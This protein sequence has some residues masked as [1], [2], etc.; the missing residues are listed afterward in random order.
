MRQPFRPSTL[1]WGLLVALGGWGLD[2]RLRAPGHRALPWISAAFLGLLAL[3]VL[4]LIRNWRQGRIP[5]TRVLL[6]IL[7]LVE[8]LGLILTRASGLALE[9]RLGTVL[10]LEVLLLV[11]AVGAWRQAR[12]LPGEW[13]EDR[14]AA[15]FE[16]FVP[17][18]AA[19]LMALELVMLGS[20][21]RYLGGGFRD[22]APEGFSHHRESGL[23]A[24]LP[25]LPLLIPGDFLL[26]KVLFSGLAPWLRWV[27]HGSTVYAVLWLFGF[28]AALKARPHQ[29]HEGQVRL[30]QGLVKSVAFPAP[31]V[32]SAAPLPEFDDDWARHAHMKGVQR[33]VARG[34]PVLELKLSEPVRVLGLLGPGCPTDRLAVSVDDPAAFLTALGQPCA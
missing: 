18:K 5:G 33:L 8:G 24:F 9:L 20:A 12:N 15:A 31:W 4:A 7:I 30:H 13:P 23:H 34:A 29:I 32:L 28:Y 14:I 10:P 22:T 17:P 26:M 25:A 27:L 11:L 3:R 6:P 19:R 21:L 16:A 2:L 1:L